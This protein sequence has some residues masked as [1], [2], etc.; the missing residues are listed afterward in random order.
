[1]ISPERDA[2]IK[3]IAL[4]TMTGKVFTSLYVPRESYVELLPEIF[5]PLGQLSELEHKR[6]MKAKPLMFFEYYK[7]TTGKF[8]AGFPVFPSF[9]VMDEEEFE[10]FRKHL[11][12]YRDQF[13]KELGETCN[14]GKELEF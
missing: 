6:L 3:R 2:Q 10:L 7:N 9:R 5:L 1:M 14:G 13:L 11:K 8:V 12:D 4:D